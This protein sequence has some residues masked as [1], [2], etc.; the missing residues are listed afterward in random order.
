M[1]ESPSQIHPSIEKQT[2]YST[3]R[4]TTDP[5]HESCLPT[6]MSRYGPWFGISSL[7]IHE[8]MNETS[9]ETEV[10][11]RLWVLSGP[12]LCVGRGLLMN[13]QKP[14]CFVIPME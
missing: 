6:D 8:R 10:I 3:W 2:N 7:F 13:F 1:I 4:H 9:A 11:L 14:F 12:S 5:A